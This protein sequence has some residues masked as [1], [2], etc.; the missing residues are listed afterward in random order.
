MNSRQA[1]WSRRRLQFGLRSVLLLT[2]LVATLIHVYAPLPPDEQILGGTL[3]VRTSLVAPRSDQVA[4]SWNGQE[5]DSEWHGRWHLYSAH[6]SLLARG[7]FDHGVAV[8]TWEY[9][10][11]HGRLLSRGSVDKSYMVGEWTSWDAERRPICQAK[12]Q[13]R[14]QPRLGG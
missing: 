11:P 3:R 4:E 5:S 1:S 8:G 10:S 14:S 9:Y 2:T 12:F 13:L 7:A 6:G